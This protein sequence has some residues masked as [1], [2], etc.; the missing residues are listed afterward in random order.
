MYIRRILVLASALMVAACD[1]ASEPEG[2]E[3]RYSLSTA[4]GGDLPI[5]ANWNGSQGSGRQ[6]REGTLRLREPDQL[7]V[8]L[9]S[10]M[11][12]EQGQAT[13]SM[14]DTLRGTWEVQGEQLKLTA[15]GAGLYA[16]GP[17][18]TVSSNRRINAVLYLVTPSYVGYGSI[19]VDV[20][21]TR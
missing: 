18:A 3:G 7:E 17:A 19:P 5:W 10:R 8:V 13:M 15:Q 9:Q 16:I 2:V 1:S 4:A 14:S 6:L 12:N 21:F 20:T 11:L